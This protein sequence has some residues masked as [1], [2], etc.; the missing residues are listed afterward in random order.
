MILGVPTLS[1]YDLLE[2]LIASAE[3]GSV[4]PSAYLII[5]NGGKYLPLKSGRLKNNMTIHRPG[6]NIGVAASWNQILRYAHERG[7]PAVI[8]NDDVEFK[9]KTFEELCRAIRLPGIGLAN[10]LGW[11]LFVQSPLTTRV[12]GPY[13]ENFFPAYYEDVDYERRCALAGV[14]RLYP[15]VTEKIFHAGSAT[16]HAMVDMTEHYEWYRRN[17]D[18]YKKK[19]GGGPGHERFALPFG[20]TEEG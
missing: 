4:R 5:D 15:C 9:E 3:R 16:S 19:W 11:A 6:R 20:G 8:S 14:R 18:Y 2:K 12:V 17:L 10:A 13:D 7:E 1:R